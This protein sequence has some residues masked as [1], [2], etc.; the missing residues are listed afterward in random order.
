[1]GILSST[2]QSSSVALRRSE[3]SGLVCGV[4]LLFSCRPRHG[5]PTLRYRQRRRTSLA[6][7]RQSTTTQPCT[8]E[9]VSPP[10]SLQR[11]PT[12]NPS[13]PFK[14]PTAAPISSPSKRSAL[15][16][17]GSAVRSS[18][19][20]DVV[21]NRKPNGPK[22]AT[23]QRKPREPSS[24]LGLLLADQKRQ[25]YDEAF[26]NVDDERVDDLMKELVGD[27]VAPQTETNREYTRKVFAAFA[28]TKLGRPEGTEFSSGITIG[29]VSHRTER[30]PF[31]LLLPLRAHY[32]DQT[33]KYA[34]FM[35]ER[36][37]RQGKRRMNRWSVARH[38]DRFLSPAI[39]GQMQAD[40]NA[41]LEKAH[42]KSVF[43]RIK[44]YVLKYPEVSAPQY[45]GDVLSIFEH[46][47][48]V[49]R[50]DQE[51][52]ANVDNWNMATLR[53]KV[54]QVTM[55]FT[56]V[57]PSSMA[58]SAGYNKENAP[59]IAGWKVKNIQLR[60]AKLNPLALQT[61]KTECPNDA[62]ENYNRLLHAKLS[63]KYI[64]GLVKFTFVK[65]R[66]LDD[67]EGSVVK[68][69]VGFEG[70]H[71]SSWGAVLFCWLYVRGAFRLEDWEDILDQGDFRLKEEAEEWEV[72]CQIKGSKL[73]P[74]KGY[75]R[76]ECHRGL[77][78]VGE[79]AGLDSTK[80]S[81]KGNRRGVA[82]QMNA[83]IGQDQA[84]Q[85]LVHEKA[86]TTD[87]GE[88]VQR[89]LESSIMRSRILDAEDRPNVTTHNNIPIEVY[90]ADENLQ[91]I[92]SEIM[93]TR[94]ELKDLLED[95]NEAP[96][97]EVQSE[98]RSELETLVRLRSNRMRV[99]ARAYRKEKN[100]EA[101]EESLP[102]PTSGDRDLFDRTKSPDSLYQYL[103]QMMHAC[104][105]VKPDSY[106]C[107][108]CGKRSTAEKAGL[109]Y[110]LLVA[111]QETAIY[112]ALYDEVKAEA[113]I[114][115]V[116]A[117]TKQSAGPRFDSGSPD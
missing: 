74:K 63:D 105:K 88:D 90:R 68:F 108:E 92:E 9:P 43:R 21:E 98:I 94:N 44:K 15:L 26:E 81:A 31:D 18:A 46:F 109:R 20:P 70:D 32:L 13:V 45:A 47:C 97:I 71:R 37:T 73:R 101:H 33:E 79:K 106:D 10:L 50:Y 67:P 3:T 39:M 107:E 24:V 35:L 77:K 104:S 82:L 110:L 29:T 95:E 41:K 40:W 49:E 48:M 55:H 30:I 113:K 96:E 102:D 28:R 59:K 64:T 57:R 75:V 93:R 22:T 86:Q 60:L 103:K 111:E 36:R 23:S 114:A 87:A 12:L 112:W 89:P 61:I 115:M 84:Q 6:N 117:V 62:D 42:R 34:L 58:I 17:P 14:T 80:F 7:P 19:N 52:V 91:K 2:A 99:V 53:S 8:W 72:L 83:I 100:M 27:A 25:S 1:M 38:V 65:K 51:I 69:S 76:R 56:G 54:A 4:K 16:T 11:P 78:A 116:D 85:A 5:L 66:T